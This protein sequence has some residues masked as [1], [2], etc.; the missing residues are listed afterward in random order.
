LGVGFVTVGRDFG[1]MP[2]AIEKNWNFFE[3]LIGNVTGNVSGNCKH[4]ISD[5]IKLVNKNLATLP[6]A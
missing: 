2:H 4:I 6:F 5:K 3:N 1:R